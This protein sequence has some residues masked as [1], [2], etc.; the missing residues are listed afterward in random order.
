[1][2]AALS[3]HPPV[4]GQYPGAHRPFISRLPFRVGG[5]VPAAPSIFG[6]REG[7]LPLRPL[8]LPVPAE[9]QGR[10]RGSRHAFHLPGA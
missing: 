9:V 7:T 5:V 10:G 2:P 4:K 1:M 8:P 6:E 3:L